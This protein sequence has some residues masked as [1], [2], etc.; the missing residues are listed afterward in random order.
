MREYE[1]NND[2]IIQFLDLWFRRFHSYRHR[3]DKKGNVI[4][5]R[6]TIN[7]DINENFSATLKAMLDQILEPIK[8]I[9]MT[10][11]TITFSFEI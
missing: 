11:H 10:P 9:S 7:H 3:V 1:V 6:F 8:F 5:H 4:R 2:T